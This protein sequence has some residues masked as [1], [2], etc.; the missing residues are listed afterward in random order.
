VRTS[1]WP[2]RPV[3]SCSAARVLKTSIAAIEVGRDVLQRERATRVP[4]NTLRPFQ[5]VVASEA[6][7]RDAIG[8]TAAAVA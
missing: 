1:I 3:S 7:D 5:V 2:A 4:V 8:F 6:A